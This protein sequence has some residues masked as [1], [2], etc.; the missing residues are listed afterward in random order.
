MNGVDPEAYLADIL[1]R[2][3]DHPIQRIDE[4][5]PWLWKTQPSAS[6]AAEPANRSLPQV[7]H[8]RTLRGLSVRHRRTRKDD[9]RRSRRQPGELLARI[10]GHPI[11]SIGSPTRRAAAP[12]QT[13]A[14][15]RTT[16]PPSAHG[17]C[18]D[19]RRR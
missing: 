1:A 4:L 17:F 6:T 15:I 5:L 13:K 2:I 12:P 8:R 11:Q 18:A 7:Q 9:R 19:F 14:H 10:A 3:A 16:I